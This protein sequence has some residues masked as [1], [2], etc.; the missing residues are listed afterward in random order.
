MFRV[1]FLVKWNGAYYTKVIIA[2]KTSI[3]KC[4]RFSACA[5]WFTRDQEGRKLYWASGNKVLDTFSMIQYMT[6]CCLCHANITM[7]SAVWLELSN[8][9]VAP[10]KVTKMSLRMPDSLYTHTWGFEQ[11]TTPK[12]VTLFLVSALELCPQSPS[13]ALLHVCLQSNWKNIYSIFLMFTL[14]L[15]ITRASLPLVSMTMFL[16]GVQCVWNC[17]TDK[18]LMLRHLSCFYS[19][20]NVLLAVSVLETANS[21][22]C[23]HHYMPWVRLTA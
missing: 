13:E 15:P 1:T 12:C 7:P 14:L 23:V 11:E 10:S 2:F 19:T 5:S 9:R 6:I 4:R 18:C 21:Q 8:S 22:Q 16:F 3:S 17:F 20:F